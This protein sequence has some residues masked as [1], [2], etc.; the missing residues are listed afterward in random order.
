VKVIFTY[1]K[2]SNRYCV[3][4][5]VLVKCDLC[6]CLCFFS[7]VSERVICVS[8]LIDNNPSNLLCLI[9]ADKGGKEEVKKK[10]K[11]TR[12]SPGLSST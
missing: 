6:Q 12:S 2:S 4:C 7:L 8:A 3:F 5:L 11:K 9:C 1:S 10:M